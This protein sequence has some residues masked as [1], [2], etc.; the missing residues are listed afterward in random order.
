[1]HNSGLSV[2]LSVGLT[3]GLG[4]LDL[5][6]SGKFGMVQ[7]VGSGYLEWPFGSGM[8][9]WSSSKWKLDGIS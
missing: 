3:S 5:K 8:V 7:F 4:V 6:H 1:M 2:E 9:L